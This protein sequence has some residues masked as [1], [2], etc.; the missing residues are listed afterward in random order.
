MEAMII[1]HNGCGVEKT[2][3][4]IGSKWSMYIVHNLFSGKKRFGELQHLLAPISPKT[5][6]QRLKELEHEGII[7][8]KVYAEVPLHVEYSLTEKGQSLKAIFRSMAKCG[9]TL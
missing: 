4:V 6:S 8:K 7:I 5:L 2:L 1:D 9:E 3:K